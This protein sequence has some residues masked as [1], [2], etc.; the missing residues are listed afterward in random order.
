MSSE[1][2]LKFLN[3]DE[4]EKVEEEA[5][6]KKR[7]VCT[8]AVLTC[9]LGADEYTPEYKVVGRRPNEYRDRETALNQIK[10]IAAEKPHFFKRMYRLGVPEFY[11]LLALISPHLEKTSK[12]STNPIPPEVYLA[13]TLRWL[14]G[15]S[16]LDLA[17]GYNLPDNA[18]HTYVFKV[19]NLIDRELKNINFPIDDEEELQRLSEEFDRFTNNHFPG[20][21][22]LST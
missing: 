16:F 15:G 2:F 12:H 14:A 5:L 1:D 19:L 20:T 21:V 13:I 22:A 9:I 4:D 3:D 11:E 18:I 8:V 17:F 7:L 10:R 6:R